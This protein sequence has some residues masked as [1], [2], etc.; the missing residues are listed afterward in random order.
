MVD[1]KEWSE[2]RNTGLLLII[3]QILHIFGWS[4]VME[5]DDDHI[6]TVYPA[7]V[8]FRGFAED[9]VSKSY[10]KINEW[11]KENAHELV[12]ETQ[13]PE[14]SECNKYEVMIDE[15]HIVDILI[16]RDTLPNDN[17]LIRWQTQQ[18]FN[19]NTWKVGRFNSTDELFTEGFE[20]T[21]SNW[22]MSRDVLRWQ[23]ISDVK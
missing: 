16:N 10:K 22:D 1:K 13:L 2:F 20:T 7:R 8:K 4:I 15:Q 9:N 5:I 11:M 23:S 12:N 14:I 17:Q 21:S 6:K 19:N 3:N 18:N